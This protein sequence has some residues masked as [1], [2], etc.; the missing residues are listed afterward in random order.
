MRTVVAA[1]EISEGILEAQC[2]LTAH[3][4]CLKRFLE[5]YRLWDADLAEAIEH[6]ETVLVSLR[7]TQKLAEQE[8][9][10]VGGAAA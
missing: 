7:G 2:G 5:R 8:T 6:S 1:T 3:L 9:K 4:R 10:R